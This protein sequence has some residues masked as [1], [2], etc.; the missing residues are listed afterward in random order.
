MTHW[1]CREQQV[2]EIA[3]IC[4]TI[5][6]EFQFS[7]KEHHYQAALETELRDAGH[8][9]Q[10]EVARLLHYEKQNSENDAIAA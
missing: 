4:C 10:Q 1:K 9:V 3:A 5:Y 7:G 2:R 8:M 6:R